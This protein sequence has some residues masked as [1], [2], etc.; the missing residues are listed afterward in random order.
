[1]SVASGKT[2]MS[3]FP[4]ASGLAPSPKTTAVMLLPGM[5]LSVS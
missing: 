2:T 1:M 3:W 5:M 4:A